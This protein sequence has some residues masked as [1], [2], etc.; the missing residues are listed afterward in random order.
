[1]DGADLRD[2]RWIA[3]FQETPRHVFVPRFNVGV[4]G[5]EYTSMVTVSP[6]W[7]RLTAISL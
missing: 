2:P 4:D 5:P 1:V 3:T 6:G 7:P